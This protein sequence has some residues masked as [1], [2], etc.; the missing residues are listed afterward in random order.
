MGYAFEAE[1]SVSDGVHRIAA[2][3]IESAVTG[4][5]AAGPADLAAAVHDARKRGKKVRG[6]LRL[7]RPALGGD[8]GPANRALRNAGRELSPL[9]DARAA[10][11]TFDDLVA[12]SRD[13]LPT[14]GLGTVRSGLAALADDAAQDPNAPRRI[15]NA[16][17]L[18]R[19]GGR[20]IE[21][22][23]LDAGGWDALGPGL[24]RTYRDGRHALADARLRRDPDAVHEWRKRV[25]DA[26]YH[27]RLLGG[28]APSVL[29]P[30]GRRFHDLADAL[31]DAHDL[32]VIRD[33][34]RREPERFGGRAPVE[35]A[36][37]LADRRRAELERRAIGLGVRLYA[38]K[39][40]AYARRVRRYRRAWR[41]LGDERPAGALA[42]VL[43]PDDEL[44]GLAIEELRDRAGEAA[45]PGRLQPARE[46]LV[47]ALRARGA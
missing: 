16:V 28:A 32:V 20:R 42:D 10:L 43:P 29:D 8:Y 5:E 3:Q 11:A 30:L 7:V 26:W 2:E 14:G 15:G 6:V 19:V 23:T 18:L 35:A 27:V 17:D 44:D 21:G 22:A 25:K 37:A 33:R 40:K 34:L 9:R 12:G 39:P 45:L 47:G 38:E 41:T 4:L 13:L 24:R 46:D 36:C 31:G 1:E